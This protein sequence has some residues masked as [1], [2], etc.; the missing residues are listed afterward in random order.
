M[1]KAL[2][3]FIL[4]LT[5]ISYIEA[6]NFEVIDDGS[7]FPEETAG[8]SKCSCTAYPT[9]LSLTD[10]PS[11]YSGQGGNCVKVSAGETTL[12]FGAC[13]GGSE[14]D[15]HWTANITNYFTKADILGFNYYN[16]TDFDFNDYLLIADWNATNTSYLRIDQWNST[17]TSYL[18]TEL[19]N[20]TNTT[21]LRIDQWNA[22]N[23]TYA[24]NQTLADMW[25]LFLG[26]TNTSYYLKENPF[27]FWNNTF[28]TFNKTYA[29]GLYFGIGNWNAT[30]T[31][32]LRIDQW[33]STN[34]TYLRIDQWNATNTTY[35]RIDQWNATNSSYRLNDNQTWVGNLN[36][37]GNTNTTISFIRD[38]GGAC[39]T[40]VSGAICRNSTG[41]YIVG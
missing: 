14:T 12:E 1:V 7:N 16:A 22:T 15:P 41:V 8:T 34:T 3:I 27:G 11:S 28:A 23:T 20:A 10:T 9:F 21:Y 37:T 26:A 30:N 13:A 40:A 31:S 19:W 38:S 33:N 17:N 32:Y 2:I 4:C 36:V 5:L 25:A 29:D 18:L 24:I 35:L 39:P 6:E